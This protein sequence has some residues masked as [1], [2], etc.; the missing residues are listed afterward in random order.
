MAV[1]QTAYANGGSTSY[2]KST[3]V[4]IAVAKTGVK[5]VHHEAEKYDIGVYF[6]ANGHGTVLFKDRVLAKLNALK[7]S[8]KEDD[9]K[10]T[11]VCRLLASATLINQAVGD[12]MSDLLFCEAVLRIRCWSVQEWSAMYADLP[13]RQAKTAV[14][15]RSM[16]SCTVDETEA[17]RP[18]GLQAALEKAMANV[19]QG[20][21]A[22]CFVRPS[23]TEDVVRVY[24]E[25]ATQE[26][27]D[28]LC[29]K[30]VQAVHDIAGGVGLRPETL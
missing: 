15:D 5:F 13:S 16:I 26:G 18:Q 7:E 28:E 6:E 14:A 3:G 27:A 10:K 30:A 8:I 9:A 12:A 2:L 23:G 24:A 21:C 17:L 29:L 25:A 20:R 22:W 4:K 19:E 11:A 1:V